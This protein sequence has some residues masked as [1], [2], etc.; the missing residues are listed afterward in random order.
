MNFRRYP[1]FL[2]LSLVAAIFLSACG[3]SDS[4]A[5][6]TPV[7]TTDN[8]TGITNN[9]ATLNGTVNPNGQATEA[10]FEWGTSPTLATSDNTTIQPFAAGTTAQAVTAPLTGL[11]FGTTYYFRLAASNASG[12]TRG[13]IGNFSTSAQRPTVTTLAAD[14][15]T[16]TSATLRGEVNPNSLDTL[17]WFEYG[18][19][20]SLATFSKTSDVGIGSGSA[21]VPT[22][23][24]IAGLTPGG[25][26]YFRAAASN[27]A[28]EQKGNILS[29][30]T[31][32]PPPVANAGPDNTVE[33]GQTVTLDGSG[34]TTPI[35]AITSYL[36]T[37]VAG[38]TVTLDNNASPTPTFT[39]LTVLDNTSEV[40][41]FQ[42]TVTDD[43]SLTASDN[44]DIIV[45]W[46]GFAD[47]F[48]TDTTGTY[49][50]TPTA[51]I[52]GTFTWD[53]AGTRV[54][55]LT[56]DDNVLK[57]SNAIPASDNG[58]FSLDFS[59]TTAYPTHGGI[60]VRLVQDANNYYV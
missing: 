1:A 21:V 25:T 5:P 8:A 52:G 15:L 18:T 49:T 44:V 32:N 6:P 4:T 20:N 17:A 27:G 38:T 54:Q 14:N 12:V 16:S 39:P 23:A 60:W 9:G 33:M 58:V 57:V 34:S 53:A 50:V 31:D 59:P 2:V 35:G 43:R 41:R 28:G 40:L 19:D 47:D 48:S 13:A 37:Q 56:G 36:W 7:V 11:T 10:W 3:D 51:G 30:S 46:V 24:N 55:V 26:V 42:L 45:N 29:L 22:S